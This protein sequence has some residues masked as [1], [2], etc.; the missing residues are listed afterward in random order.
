M[1]ASTGVMSYLFSPVLGEI[2]VLL[3]A[4]VMLRLLPSGITGGMRKGI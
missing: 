4:I 3:V 1:A 2:I